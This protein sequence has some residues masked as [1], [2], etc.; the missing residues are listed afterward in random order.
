MYQVNHTQLY[1]AFEEL[2]RLYRID[3]IGAEAFF[4]PTWIEW[5]KTSYQ[6]IAPIV[7]CQT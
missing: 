2:H 4:L 6:H 3:N 1:L 5:G 7:K